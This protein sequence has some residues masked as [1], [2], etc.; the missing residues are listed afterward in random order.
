MANTYDHS[1]RAAERAVKIKRKVEQ[2]LI[3]DA[4]TPVSVMAQQLGVSEAIFTGCLPAEMAKFTSGLHTE[5]VLAAL[6]AWGNVTTIIA[7]QGSLFEVK[8]DFP[9]GK[10]A[11]GF[12]NLTGEQGQLTG[13]LR[14]DRISEIAFVCKPFRHMSSCYIAFFT[15][16]GEC[17]FKVYLGRDKQRQLFP[18]QVVQFQQLQQ[19]LCR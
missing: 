9:P 4:N 7:N 2:M 6:P 11:N 17:V 5:T 3:T 10:M 8:A 13:H 16:R 12:Y 14:L 18:Q 1:I 19:E 15:A